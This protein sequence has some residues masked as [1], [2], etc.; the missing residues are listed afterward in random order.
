VVVS[1]KEEATINL[2]TIVIYH[3]RPFINMNCENGIRIISFLL[4]SIE[5]ENKLPRLKFLQGYDYEC[6]CYFECPCECQC[7]ALQVRGEKY[8][9][10]TLSG[11]KVIQRSPE[12]L[13]YLC[14][15]WKEMMSIKEIKRNIKHNSS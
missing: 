8:G 4:D 9:I 5:I 10:H 12:F 7:H 2:R 3:S 14:E 11:M 1:Q 13:L 6:E 15:T